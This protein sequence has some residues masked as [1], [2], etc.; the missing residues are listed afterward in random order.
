LKLI[1][2]QKNKRDN[3]SIILWQIIVALLGEIG[4][5]GTLYTTTALY[6]NQYLVY[7]LLCIMTI[8]FMFGMHIKKIG[9]YMIPIIDVILVVLCVLFGKRIIQ[10]IVYIVNDIYDSIFHG[11]IV[12]PQADK[13]AIIKVNELLAVTMFCVV[14]TFLV[15]ANIYYVRSIAL[16][17]I[18]V[19]PLLCV[20]TVC[21][22]IPSCFVWI[23]CITHVLCVSGMDEKNVCNVKKILAMSAAISAIMLLLEPAQG[24]M[25]PQIFIRMNTNIKSFIY[26]NEYLSNII[27]VVDELVSGVAA[28]GEN[29]N[30]R[31]VIYGDNYLFSNYIKS[32]ELG[33]VDKISYR[34]QNLFTMYTPSSGN[35]QYIS[36]FYGK[37]Y[38]EGENYW[39]RRESDE[40]CD[41]FTELL[42]KRVEENKGWKNY[43]EDNG[44]YMDNYFYKFNRSFSKK[45][46]S[47]TSVIEISRLYYDKLQKISDGYIYTDG[48]EHKVKDV[49]S[50]SLP[51][52]SASA[53]AKA[54][55][56]YL[57]ISLKQ[58]NL[59]YDSV[60][61]MNTDTLE[62]KL[63]CIENVKTFLK[64]HYKYTL[65]PGR[66]PENTD[67]FEYFLTDSKQGYCTYF[68]TAATLMF[69]AYGLPARYVEGYAVS[70]DRIINSTYENNMNRHIVNVKD[71]D[72]HAWTQ[73]YLDGI[74]WVNVD[75]TPAG[76]GILAAITQNYPE[77]IQVN[78][79][80]VPIEEET[81]VETDNNAQ[82]N[83]DETDEEENTAEDIVEPA[84]SE[85]A[86]E[87]KSAA[88][89]I[90]LAVGSIMAVLLAGFVFYAA[91]MKRKTE[92]IYKSKN[93]I[94]MYNH[95]EK[96]MT[97]AGFLRP[98]YMEYESFGRYMEQTD[99]FFR[100]MKFSKVCGLVRN[101]DLS[102]GRYAASEKQLEENARKIVS[103]RKY[104]LDNI[105]WYLRWRFWMQ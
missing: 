49:K 66:I 95:L 81:E 38:V 77:N 47:D 34:E 56:K 86:V 100:K 88:G 74:G 2:K 62:Q 29:I 11:K 69:R 32:G 58:K 97:K 25:R 50:N 15:C 84:A 45:S 54:S 94:V 101:L 6:V 79:D 78:E 12:T 18:M 28:D 21:L 92:K 73:V 63:N 40:V 76:T 60:G 65:E 46:I 30:D 96:L 41:N 48:K 14:V 70:A 61:Y 23:F 67:F 10:G 7:S 17:L 57:D 83:L 27:N 68:A 75:A 91:A 85:V 102:G 98:E 80:E 43:L 93:I 24:Y 105:P 99:P 64:A 71:S 20:Y 8:L 53:T 59:I 72:A 16:S 31:S 26:T 4:I 22:T 44:L 51:K 9:K 39:Q 3:L 90:I 5:I 33:K 13:L 89:I 35:H 36:V 55:E 19:L 104:I 103:L 1:D 82:E 87:N 37:N 52:D 42:L